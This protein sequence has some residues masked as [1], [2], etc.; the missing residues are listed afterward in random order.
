MAD[1]SA[2]LSAAD[3]VALVRE[4]IAAHVETGQALAGLVAALGTIE[5]KL[6]AIETLLTE[7]RAQGTLLVAVFAKRGFWVGIAAGGAIG[8]AIGSA[9]T[10]KL[11]DLLAV[12][13]GIP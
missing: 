3:Y 8:F 5:A 4:Q 6:T 2:S 10:G 9:M 1:D 13:Q 12:M 11:G 7:L